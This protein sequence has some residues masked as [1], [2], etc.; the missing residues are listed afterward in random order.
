MMAILVLARAYV[1][2]RFTPTVFR[3][4][5]L[6]AGRLPCYFILCLLLL[7]ATPQTRKVAM[8]YLLDGPRTAE[9]QVHRQTRKLGPY[10]IQNGSA[11]AQPYSSIGGFPDVPNLN[12]GGSGVTSNPENVPDT[13]YFVEEVSMMRSAKDQAWL[14]EVVGEDGRDNVESN[15]AG[16]GYEKGKQQ[17]EDATPSSTPSVVNDATTALSSTSSL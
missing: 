11:Q 1:R 3:S 17:M 14:L 5:R 6:A 16:E 10:D 4:W 9:E 12:N 8:G 2:S 13:T 15:A 7:E